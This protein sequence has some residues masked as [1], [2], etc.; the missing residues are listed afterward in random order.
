MTISTASEDQKREFET[1]F[2]LFVQRLQSLLEVEEGG[3]ISPES[4]A[5]INKLVTEYWRL[6]S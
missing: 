1:H 6:K 4:V 2:Q 3:E 5:K